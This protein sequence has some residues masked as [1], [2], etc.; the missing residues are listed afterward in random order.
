MTDFLDVNRKEA[1]ATYS[2]PTQALSKQLF[3]MYPKIMET[4]KAKESVMDEKI[5]RRSVSALINEMNK[6][7]IAKIEQKN[8]IKR[9]H[10]R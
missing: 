7:A 10:K 9:W 2:L 4:E 6:N 3:D 5:V 1:Y 8:E